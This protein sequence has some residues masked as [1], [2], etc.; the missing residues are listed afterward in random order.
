MKLL[1]NAG[2]IFYGSM[3]VGL[4]GQQ[5]FYGD[6]RPVILPG[7]SAQLPFVAYVAYPVSLLMI[8][9][10]TAIVLNRKALEA[11]LFT[12]AVFLILFLF[13]QVSYELLV[14]PYPK[15]LGVWTNALKELALAGG[16][17][18]VAGTVGPI[19]QKSPLFQGVYYLVPFAGVFF[20]VTMALF[21]IDHFLYP[22]F[23]ASLVPDWIPG[24]YFWTYFA[25]VAL[26]GS[27]LAIIINVQAK[28]AAL[29][30]GLMIFI[31]L[32]VLHIPRVL[33]APVTDR[34]NELTSVF[35]ALG[36][37]GTAWMIAYV[38]KR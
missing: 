29:L 16:A 3:L 17:F 35:E 20:S 6:F 33:N 1:T 19:T 7:W 2:R 38:R 32:I 24:H 27:G 25:G 15:H 5:I 4:A 37:S 8:V 26:I 9:A 14:D 31:W 10:G 30:L 18:A 13:G 22:D 34:G 21:G 36:F 28:P 12:G 23:V 11:A